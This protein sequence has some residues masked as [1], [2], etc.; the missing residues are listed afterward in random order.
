MTI[1]ATALAAFNAADAADAGRDVARCCGCTAFVAAIVAGRPYAD[2]DE[3]SAA[4]DAEFGRLGWADV[5]EALAGHPRIGERQAAGWSRGE[6]AGALAAP[7]PVARE[8]AEGNRIYEERFGH[9]FLVCASGLS[10]EQMLAA[11][12]ARLAN[13]PAAERAVVTDELRKITQLRMRKLL[14]G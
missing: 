14:T 4:I 7:E 1:S 5:A 13:D 8:L 10:G 6:Q 2:L 3:L 9:V 11:L 12:R